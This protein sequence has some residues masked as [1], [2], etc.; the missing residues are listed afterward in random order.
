LKNVVMMPRQP[1]EAM[2]AVWSMCDISLISLR[3]T[4]LFTKVIPSKIFESMGMGLPMVI[5]CPRGEAT[6]ILES[7]SSGLVVEPDNP[8]ALAEGIAELYS[9]R[10]RLAELA[11]A[12]GASAG[13]YDRAQ[14]ARL[15]LESLRC[16][17]NC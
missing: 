5:A 4:P 8:Q 2:P 14:Q 1:K 9:D 6:E 11:S 16:A 12:S 3:D 7:T 17:A 13:S 15:M 10:T